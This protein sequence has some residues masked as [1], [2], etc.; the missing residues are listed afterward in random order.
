MDELAL[1][2]AGVHV[3]KDDIREWWDAHHYCQ[4]L[5]E[6]LTQ[7][8]VYDTTAPGTARLSA[9]EYIVPDG[10]YRQFPAG[11]RQ[12]WHPH[13]FEVDGGL[14]ALPELPVDSARALLLAIR[15]TWGKTWHLWQTQ[16]GA[17]YPTGEPE[18]AWAIEGP[19]SI[20]PG[21]VPRGNAVVG[22]R[23]RR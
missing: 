18:L 9:I 11:E 23:P 17:R 15:T 2:L 6:D 5:R 12:Y 1:Y 19:D 7:C 8:A 16:R 20:P 22:R 21:V 13:T 14:L 4:A 10:V 3:M